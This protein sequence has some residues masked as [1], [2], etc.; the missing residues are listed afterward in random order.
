MKHHLE[1]QENLSSG[2]SARTHILLLLQWYK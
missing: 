2:E 1:R